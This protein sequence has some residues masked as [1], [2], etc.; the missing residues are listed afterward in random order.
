MKVTVY[1]HRDKETNLDTAQGLELNEKAQDEFMYAL[2]EVEFDLEVNEDGS[3]RVTEVRDSDQVLRPVNGGLT[4]GQYKA[5]N[6]NPTNRSR[7]NGLLVS[8]E[9]G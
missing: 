5:D 1:L 3:Y 9:R 7:S 4:D 6:V 8:T 2:Y